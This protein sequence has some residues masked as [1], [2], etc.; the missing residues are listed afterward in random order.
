MYALYRCDILYLSIYAYRSGTLLVRFR[1]V[2]PFLYPL[3]KMQG[4]EMSRYRWTYCNRYRSLCDAEWATG[5]GSFTSFM[6]ITI[7]C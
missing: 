2:T 1:H 3:H 6:C 7:A 4:Q 5:N